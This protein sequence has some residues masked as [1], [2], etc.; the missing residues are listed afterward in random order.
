MPAKLNAA[1]IA[2]L[3][4]QV[5]IDPAG[6]YSTG[7]KMAQLTSP[8]PDLVPK[9]IAALVYQKVPAQRRRL[10]VKNKPVLTRP[11]QALMTSMRCVFPET[12]GRMAPAEHQQS[13]T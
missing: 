5:R 4:Q 8:E 10:A 11:D 12:R 7:K 13:Y 1:E 2:R 9:T 3:A 6:Y